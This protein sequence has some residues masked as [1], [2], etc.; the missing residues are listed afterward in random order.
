MPN[1]TWMDDLADL[2]KPEDPA[3]VA[4]AFSGMRGSVPIYAALYSKDASGPQELAFEARNNAQSQAL[5]DAQYAALQKRQGLAAIPDEALRKAVA[6]RMSEEERYPPAL[7]TRRADYAPQPRHEMRQY[8]DGGAVRPDF[9]QPD[10][11]DGGAFIPDQEYQKGGGV[12]KSLQQM[13]EELL[14]KGIKTADTPDLARRSLFGLKAQ[15]ALDLPLARI[16]DIQKDLA[17]APA[18][19]EKSVT[20]DPGQGAAKSTLKSLTETPMSRRAVMQTAAGQVLR[21][22]IPG[23]NEALP[24]PDLAGLVE[25][26]AKVAPAALTADMIPAFIMTAMRQGMSKD[27]A[28]RA[29]MDQFK[30]KQPNPMSD[31]FTMDPSH[32]VIDPGTGKPVPHFFQLDTLYDTLK[33]PMFAAADKEFIEP[34]R[35]SMALNNLLSPAQ[36][37]LA[38]PPLKLRG[39]LRQMRDADPERYRQLINQAKDYSTSTGESAIESGMMTPKNLERFMRGLDENPKYRPEHLWTE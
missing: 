20:I 19:T 29:T 25:S 13:A 6:A 28:I 30:L 33:D 11:A 17:K 9:T 26:A 35:P 1:S 22:A 14:G 4:S 3:N 31:M 5:R 12:K 7:A 21:H 10:M 38:T 34:L 23:L 36:I 27:D 2:L 37:D 16:E 39:A 18:I 8:A 32:P 24:T 15:P